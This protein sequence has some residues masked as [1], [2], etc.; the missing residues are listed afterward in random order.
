MPDHLDGSSEGMVEN[1]AKRPRST[2]ATPKSGK[3]PNPDER[4]RL[5]AIDSVG[6]TSEEDRYGDGELTDNE[7]SRIRVADDS[8]TSIDSHSGIGS[9]PGVVAGSRGFGSAILAKILSR[10]PGFDAPAACAS[11]GA[12]E[13]FGVQPKPRDSA[14]H[15]VQQS[16][17]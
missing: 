13:F 15:L 7:V 3:R 16:G 11:Q 5:M 2:S 4:N 8:A 17:F 14:S 6:P 9:C 1:N 10:I 12:A